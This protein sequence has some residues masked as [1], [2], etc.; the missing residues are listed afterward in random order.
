MIMKISV[1]KGYT[2]Q[3]CM[4]RKLEN[5]VLEYESNQEKMD[6]ANALIDDDLDDDGCAEVYPQIEHGE[7]DDPLTGK[8]PANDMG[9]FD[10]DRPENQRQ[11]NMCEDVGLPPNS[12]MENGDVIQ[13]R[14]TEKDYISLTRKLNR[15]KENSFGMQMPGT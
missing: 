14:I 4:K 1:E 6:L 3:P 7:Q 10:P 15:H 9:F 5:K 11:Y 8:T 2:F 12:N 13:G